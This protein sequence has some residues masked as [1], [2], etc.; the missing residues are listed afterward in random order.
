MSVVKSQKIIFINLRFLQKLHK[1]LIDIDSV[2]S[3][4]AFFQ[5]QTLA[6]KLKINFENFVVVF[7]KNNVFNNCTVL[8]SAAKVRRSVSWMN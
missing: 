7:C 2:P 8:I 3:L 1:K 4:Q 6:Y 5:A